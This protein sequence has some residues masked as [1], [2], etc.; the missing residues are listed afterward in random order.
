MWTTCLLQ[1]IKDV[2][3]MNVIS[4]IENDLMYRMIHDVPAKFMDLLIK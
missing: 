1:G 2:S 3:L 4:V